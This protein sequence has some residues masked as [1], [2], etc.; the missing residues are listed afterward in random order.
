MA[1]S[2]KTKIKRLED[3]IKMVE[4]LK[5]EEFYFGDFV[6]EGD[7][8]NVCGTICCVAGWYPKYFPECG[9][10]YELDDSGNVDI[11]Y[12]IGIRHTLCMWHGLKLGTIEAMIYPTWQ[13]KI[14]EKYLDSTAT[15]Q[16]ILNLY[17]NILTRLKNGEDL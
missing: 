11:T 3:T 9:L 17:N 16:E 10:A 12:D 6:K 13:D 5:D 2:L 4:N 8:K 14:N 7:A 1:L 15:L